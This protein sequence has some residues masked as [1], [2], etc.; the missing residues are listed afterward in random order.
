MNFEQSKNAISRR[1]ALKKGSLAAGALFG[2]ASAAQAE[3]IRFKR[4]SPNDLIELGVLTCERTHT[5]GLWGPLINAVGKTRT[6]GMVMTYCWDVNEEKKLEFAKKYNCKP[7]KNFDDMLGK[8]DGIINGNYVSIMC[9]HKINQPYLE[10]GVPTFINRPFANSMR[11]AKETIAQ[12]KKGDAPI[13][14]TSSFEF[15]RDVQVVKHRVKDW[16]I[17]GYT[18][19]NSMSDYSTHGIHGLWMCL[20]V[21]D[22]PVVS[23][24]YMTPDWKKPN[25]LVVVE[26]KAKEDGSLYYGA[27]QEVPGGLTNAHIKVYTTGAEFFEQSL[28]WERGPHDRDFA[29]WTPMLLY[30]QLMVEHGK[31]KMSES[32]ES[33]EQKTATYLAAFKSHLE[34]GGKLVKLADLDDEWEGI[35]HGGG[36]QEKAY[37]KYFGL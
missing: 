4:K 28:W 37:R 15:T 9:N 27:L 3:T 14:S 24:A 7:V 20:K 2:G 30:F 11:I 1:D 23:A 25:G 5:W 31:E 12:A 17:T 6:T 32:Y 21:V 22:D 10:A 19:D 13:M 35:V 8:V 34:E 29:M 33:I 26:H 16:K 18:A 36:E